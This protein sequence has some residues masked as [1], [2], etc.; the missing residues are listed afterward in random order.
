VCSGRSSRHHAFPRALTFPSYL[1][2]RHRPRREA[3]PEGAFS[4]AGEREKSQENV[5]SEREKWWESFF[6]AWAEMQRQVKGEEETRAE[7]D[8]IEDLLQLPPQSRLL[9]VPCG[10]GR[11]SL[12]VA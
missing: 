5:M 6:P 12:E 2:P 4:R 10:E 3:A 9:D 7:A 11:L 8:C 1:L